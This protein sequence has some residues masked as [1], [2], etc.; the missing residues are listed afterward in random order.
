MLLIFRRLAR[1]ELSYVS[2]IYS[3]GFVPARSLFLRGSQR[4]QQILTSKYKLF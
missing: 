4:S 2:E 3:Q 1:E